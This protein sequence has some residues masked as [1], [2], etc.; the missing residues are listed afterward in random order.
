[1]LKKKRK[2]KSTNKLTKIAFFDRDDVLN[3][4]NINNG[5]VGYKKDF[6]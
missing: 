2:S 6:K 1:M 5:Y 3:S 4:S